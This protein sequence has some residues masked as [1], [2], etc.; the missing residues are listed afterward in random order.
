[1]IIMLIP[2]PSID[3]LSA[4]RVLA[5]THEGYSTIF[6]YFFENK[7]CIKQ[8]NYFVYDFMISIGATQ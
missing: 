3:K 8:K 4:V 7:N 6:T 1:M 5:A 2:L